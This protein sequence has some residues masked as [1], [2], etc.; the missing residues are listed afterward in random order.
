MPKI[1]V[2]GSDMLSTVSFLNKGKHTL[3]T[4][5]VF[6]S[7]NSPGNSPAWLQSLFGE[8]LMMPFLNGGS[9]SF[10]PARQCLQNRIPPNGGLYFIALTLLQNKACQIKEVG[11]FLP[12][13]TVSC[14]IRPHS[15]YISSAYPIKFWHHCSNLGPLWW[16]VRAS[17]L[18]HFLF[19][20][21]PRTNNNSHDGHC[22]TSSGFLSKLIRRG[23]Q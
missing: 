10:G 12:I 17:L 20:V 3:H 1:Q 7:S 23:G 5:S 8:S 9:Q 16:T 11:P 14:R 21:V 6:K 15:W 2:A 18:L 13:Y 22:R 19:H 4:R